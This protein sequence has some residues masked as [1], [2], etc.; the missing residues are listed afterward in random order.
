MA[1][2]RYEAPADLDALA[3][4]LAAAGPDTTC[5]EAGP[6]CCPASTVGF[7]PGRH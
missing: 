3:R 4:C 1:S 6:T 2:I 7:P 5:W